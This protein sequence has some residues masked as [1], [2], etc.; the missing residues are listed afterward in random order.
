MNNLLLEKTNSSI[1][2]GDI[3][4]EVPCYT[5][6]RS[7]NTLDIIFNKWITKHNQ[8]INKNIIIRI[9]KTKSLHKLNRKER[10]DEL[11]NSFKVINGNEIKN[12]RIIIYDDII[13]T[14]STI[15][16]ISEELTKYHP[17]EIHALTYTRTK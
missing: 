16:K 6:K 14:G 17:K 13:T 9:K 4:I 3:W 8:T 10:L 1:L 2:Q 15:Q 12:K 5:N 7:Y 11:E